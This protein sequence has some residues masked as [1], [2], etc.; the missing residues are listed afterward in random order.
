MKYKT[1]LKLF[2][3]LHF[4]RF[5]WIRNLS[6]KLKIFNEVWDKENFY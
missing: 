2:Y 6:Y 4:S 3:F 5:E 1:K